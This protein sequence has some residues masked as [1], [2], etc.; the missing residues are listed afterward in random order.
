MW[1]LAHKHKP[2]TSSW[3]SPKHVE[4]KYNNT[5]LLSQTI[6]TITVNPAAKIKR[7]FTESQIEVLLTEVEGKKIIIF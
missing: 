6:Q 5:P 3:I 7:N 4:A 1:N 2:V